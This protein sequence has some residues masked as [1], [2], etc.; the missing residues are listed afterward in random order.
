[1][2]TSQF[3]L[4]LFA[5]T[6]L[7]A[8][9][10]LPAAAQDAASDDNGQESV[11]SGEIVVTGTLLRG[12]EVVGS[13]TI[14]VGA[15]DIA[16]KGA[17]STNQLLGLIPQIANTFN[18]RF[19]GDPRG[20]GAGISISRPNLRNL[21]SSN[22]TS[23]GLTLVLADGMR[24]APV[25]VNQASVDVD[26]I[27]AAVLSR[28]D[29]VTDGGS[30]LYGA[31][32]VGG[33]LNFR[34]LPRFE[35]VK[36]DANNGFGTTLE[37]YK[38]WDGAI[39]AGAS[40]EGGNAYI[41]ASHV[42]RNEVLNG[43]TD[44]STGTVYNSAGVGSF[45]FTQCPSAVGTQITYRY[46]AIPGV[47][48][49]WTNNPA[50]GGRTTPIGT[51]CD[52]VAAQSYSPEQKRTNVFGAL[53]QELSDTVDLR[54]TG[55]WAKRDTEL[56]N[57]SR[58]FTTAAA[59]APSGAPGTAGAPATSPTTILGGTGFSFDVNPAYVNTPSQVGFETWGISPE[60][61]VKL[62]GNWQLRNNLHFG[63]ST[64]YQSFPGVDSV[65]TQ[66][67]ITAGQLNPLN[68]AAASASV[69]N[70][71]TN[72]ANLQD[73]KHQLMTLRSIA[74]GTL[75]T[76]PGGDVKLAVGVEFQENKAE[77]RLTAG[78][79]G[80][81]SA[82]PY[83]SAKRNSKSAFAEVLV[84]VTSFA[85]VTGSVR[86][87]DYSDF[88]STTN[89]SVGLALKPTTWLKLFGHWNTSF[90]APTAIDNIAIG[91]G[92]FAC[93]IYVPGSTSAASRPNDPLGRDTSRQGSC[94]MVL[95][96]S[97]PG[98]KP[99]TA[100]A[101]A[102][103]FEAT[104][105]DGFRFGANYYSID[106]KNALGSLNPSVTS[107]YTTN[108]DLYTYN[109]TASQYSALLATL[110]NGAALGAQ[111]PASNIAL[112]VDTRTT[113]LNAAQIEG[114][115]FNMSFQTET[116]IGQVGLGLNGNR[117]TKA[118][119]TKG[120]VASDELGIG[121]PKTRL[122]T[123]L[124]YDRGALSSRVT[125]NYSGKFKDEATNY[126][127][128]AEEVKEF[129]TTNVNMTLDLEKLSGATGVTLRLAMDN[130]TNEKPQIVRRANTNNPSYVNWTLGRVVKI[131]A[132]V[133]F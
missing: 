35:G 64:N 90:N 68:A 12:T 6:A 34:T 71:I 62:G 131:G 83:L 28:I 93:G 58:G 40:W 45:S 132:S 39:T 26:I 57:Y 63:R 33:V 14:S 50:A 43:D 94:A 107:T 109:I 98:L 126:L 38:Y 81:L 9:W 115:D 53:S 11:E 61:T 87:D 74:D 100:D 49:G 15:E 51:A 46:L 121:G 2:K 78:P 70:D 112:V 65:K 116:K 113:N 79:F 105:A 30:S 99:Q 117:Q 29:V 13:Q 20:Y 120:G 82:L 80:S 124:T 55:Y 41:S 69:I 119:I 92:R 36:I 21:P 66:A 60:V 127:G 5:A 44:W 19:E 25:G 125:V 89:P 95:Q 96:G 18:G 48:T 37:S 91:T 102:I 88:G 4:S 86:Y 118:F 97:S 7:C 42:K 103:G 106:V 17:A 110:T 59:P 67:Y 85:D 3:K 84:P 1:M 129:I 133:K 8:S 27:P 77:S 31:D 73:T 47:F 101:W 10:A 23:G 114:I 128:V 108:P 56:A 72:Y 75:F 130:V 123:Y 122:A 32:A 104:P 24:F 22:T 54:V 111:Q 52:N 16:A 76:A